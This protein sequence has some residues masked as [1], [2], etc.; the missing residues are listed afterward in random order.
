[1]FIYGIY[2]MI[3]RYQHQRIVYIM[4]ICYLLTGYMLIYS[5]CELDQKLFG[6]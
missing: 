6:K 5:V 4:Y 2:H 3:N 1:M